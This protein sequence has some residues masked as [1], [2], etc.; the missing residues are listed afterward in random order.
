[1]LHGEEN[2]FW[3][4]N[5][6]GTQKIH[7]RVIIFVNLSIGAFNAHM[8]ELKD[9]VDHLSLFISKEMPNRKIIHAEMLAHETNDLN[10]VPSLKGRPDLL[11][12]GRKRFVTL[13][14]G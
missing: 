13:E 9:L 12:H 8:I 4:R 7:H 6:D 11:M 14:I 3:D 10:S 1:M 5:V 2:R